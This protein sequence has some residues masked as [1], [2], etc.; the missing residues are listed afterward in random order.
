[1]EHILKM[2][3]PVYHFLTRAVEL[4]LLNLLFIVC[5]IP[6]ITMGTSITALYSVTLK[7]VR[8]EDSG[9]YREFLQAFKQN[10]RQSTAIWSLLLVAGIVLFMNYTLLGFYNGNFSLLIILSLFFF[11]FF[12][13]LIGTMIFPYIARFKNTTKDAFKN[14]IK[15]AIA[16]PYPIFLV[17]IFVIGPVILMFSSPFFFV[18]M[19]YINLFLGFSF[20]AYL[21]S[22]IIRNLYEKYED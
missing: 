4:T 14:V 8:K 2:E 9:I 13:L 19:L 15:M 1:M 11:S 3:G 10:F 21:N 12:Y 16:N 5:S 17:L 7:M 18:L 20:V 22:F 6:I